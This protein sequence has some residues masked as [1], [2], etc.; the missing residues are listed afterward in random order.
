MAPTQLSPAASSDQLQSTTQTLQLLR[1]PR[2][3]FEKIDP[4]Q[5]GFDWMQQPELTSVVSSFETADEARH[6]TIRA[7]HTDKAIHVYARCP[8]TDPL[9]MRPHPPAAPLTQ[10][11]H[12]AI[13][14][15]PT[16]DPTLAYIFRGDA[17]GMREATIRHRVTGEANLEAVHTEWGKS[18]TNLQ[19][20]N[21]YHGLYRDHWSI[22]FIIPWQ[23]IGL[24]SRPP[25]IG[26]GCLHSLRVQVGLAMMYGSAWPV[27]ASGS[28]LPPGFEIGEILLDPDAGAPDGIELVAPKFG[29]NVA[30][31]TLGNQWPIRPTSVQIRTGSETHQVPVNDNTDIVDLPFTLTRDAE[32]YTRPLEPL[33][34]QFNVLGG[35][36]DQVLYSATL[37]FGRHAGICVEE[38]FDQKNVEPESSSLRERWLS[39]IS[40]RLPQLI[41]RNT[42]EGAPSDFCLCYSDGSVAVNLMADD[43]WQQ[44]AAIVE[45]RFETTAER[46]IASMMLIGQKSVTNLIN[47]EQFHNQ[48][49][50]QQYHTPM[51][52][53]MGPLSTVRYG[54]GTPVARATALAWLLRFVSDPATG[55]PFNT[56]VFSLDENGGPRHTVDHYAGSK[57]YAYFD[58]HPGPIGAVAVDYAD[59]LTILDPSSL[60]FLP[61]T[62]QELA[63]LKDACADESYF[64]THA[65]EVQ[66]IYQQI[67]AAEI[68]RFKPNR[69]LTRGVFPEL[70]PD[71][72]GTDQPFDPA[73]RQHIQA[74]IAPKG[75]TT[76]VDGP[77][78]DE[79]HQAG[80]RD[81][82]VSVNWDDEKLSVVVTARGLD[83]SK[84]DEADR[85]F[86]RIN[87]AVDSNHNHS[88]FHRFAAGLE[89]KRFASLERTGLIQTL[90][91]HLSTAQWNRVRPIESDGWR[92]EVSEQ[93]DG[94][95]LWF[96][97]PWETLG[98]QD[99]ADLPPTIGL[100]VWIDARH[101][102]YE[103]TFLVP[104]RFHLSADAFSFA[105][106]Y[107]NDSPVTVDTIDYG[108]P[109]WGTN[110][111]QISLT[112]HSDDAKNVTLQ[113]GQRC[114][115]VRE[116][117]QC[118]PVT[119]SVPANDTLDVTVDY[120]LSPKEK[121][122]SGS[123]QW[124]DWTVTIDGDV[125]WQAH[126][127]CTY[128]G[129][130]YAYQRY[131]DDVPEVTVPSADHPEYAEL[132]VQSICR[133]LPRFV[134][135]T[136]RDGAISDFVIE[137]EDGS[138]TFNLME[139]GV[140][141]QM[142]QY[143]HDRFNN[144]LDRLLG[145]LMFNYAPNVLRH[146]SGGH[147]F[148]DGAGPLSIF[149]GNHAGAG[150]N[151]GYHSRAFA[152]LLAHMKIDGERIKANSCGV[153]GHAISA[154]QHRDSIVYIDGDVG[155]V[156][157]TDDGKDIATIADLRKN[158]AIPTTANAGELMRYFTADE[159]HQ[160]CRGVINEDVFK[161][162]FPAGAPKT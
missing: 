46:L 10:T 130:L 16:N 45:S 120:Y 70:C 64:Q 22:E 17:R 87:V 41:R 80:D 5:P 150:G 145:L 116:S 69:L 34:V 20:W 159:V 31:M 7:G 147:R 85:V 50:Q 2:L 88:T 89:G 56:R 148:M 30:S 26:F 121:M 75:E 53:M 19:D 57:A 13:T 44:L 78:V 3:R 141:D 154:F 36:N 111:A 62:D 23:A 84:W 67:D 105:D 73:I 100:N 51:H 91:K 33:R 157:L 8:I 158:P 127:S 98:I 135:K 110:Q 32:S 125:Q 39:R 24:K 14:L 136:T 103:Q 71:E 47:S 86:E 43:A 155:H 117:R 112:N 42:N 82:T 119:V 95:E 63:T 92:L 124:T 162:V 79:D 108:V 102:H 104:P 149:R 134:R 55:E 81:A 107:L 140:L 146:M 139:S 131:G 128:C 114:G 161:G 74:F 9:L 151:C 60:V 106:V 68:R 28:G 94:Y 72:D 40:A 15:Y 97:L 101:P 96:E 66:D 4:A 49:W 11:E 83:L 65:R 25:V 93:Q 153:W 133:Q 21:R 123:P 59:D 138:V 122:T 58:L 37:P 77:F 115:M 12:I 143:I 6:A 132:K 160:L 1:R 152:G 54:G 52:K 99:A 118:A 38:V 48:Q 35:P 109:T 144:N 129:D 137:A 156:M 27:V 61:Q 29:K 90:C 142:C 126:A 76:S 113:T 18:E